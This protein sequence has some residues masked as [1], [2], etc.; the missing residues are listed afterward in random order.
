MIDGIISGLPSDPLSPTSLIQSIYAIGKAIYNHIQLIKANKAQFQ[1][2]SNRV[3]V[4]TNI[5]RRLEKI[6]SNSVVAALTT[7]HEYLN[8]CLTFM[9]KFSV[10]SKFKLFFLKTS[11]YSEQFRE[12]NQNLSTAIQDLIL[13]VSVQNLSERQ[14]L[15]DKIK[16]GFNNPQEDQRNCEIDINA[17]RELIEQNRNILKT[18]L[19]QQVNNVQQESRRSCFLLYNEL[20][21]EFQREIAS[22]RKQWDNSSDSKCY[23]LLQGLNLVNYSYKFIKIE[24]KQRLS[25]TTQMHRQFFADED[26][27]HPSTEECWQGYPELHL[28][29]I[30]SFSQPPR[31]RRCFFMYRQ[32]PIDFRDNIL[33]ALSGR[34]I[35]NLQLEWDT[36]NNESN[37]QLLTSLNLHSTSSLFLIGEFIQKF[38][39]RTQ[40][41]RIALAEQRG[42]KK[43]TGR[44]FW[45]EFPE[46]HRACMKNI[47]L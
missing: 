11:N 7:L 16:Q 37:Y 41:Q 25:D 13:G 4:I 27:N 35:E 2:L 24:F 8:H 5:I 46:L 33:P 40:L 44:E 6:I 22:V 1:A 15:T 42:D 26:G 14:E 36:N 21:T 9:K 12:L 43:L 30:G 38:G 34:Q 31:E 45:D 39:E 32:L 47:P 20:E 18:L 3:N 17:N 19:Q 29:W 10:S 23:Q 28:S